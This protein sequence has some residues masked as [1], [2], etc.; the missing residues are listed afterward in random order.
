M[1]E[2]RRGFSAPAEVTGYFDGKSDRPGFSWLDVWGEE[3]AY[4]WTVAKA[5]DLELRTALR[6]AVS[7]GIAEGRTFENF[8]KD[9]EPELKR[10]GWWEPRLV[11]DPAGIDPD[12]IVDFSSPRRLQ[13]IYWS[14]MRAA[15]A[16]GQWQRIERA[17]RGLPFL[18]Y[19]RSSSAD[20]RPEHLAWVGVIL[21]VDHPW[22]RAHFPPNGW[23]CL[24]SV[25][26][27]SG[28]EAERLLAR[29]PKEGEIRYVSEP[30]D[31]GPP[32]DF[33]NRRTGEITVVPAGID[34][35]WHTS[36]GRARARTLIDNL[37]AR[38]DEADPADA[39]PVVEEAWKDPFAAIVPKLEE[40][41]WL[42]AGVSPKLETDLKAASPI[43][44]V[45]S[46]TI[47]DRMAKHGMTLDDF[48]Q[49]PQILSEA[50]VL[51]DLSP[52][53]EENVRTVFARFDKTWWRAIVVRSSTGLMRIRSLHQRD[54]QRV[55]DAILD[56]GLGEAM[57]LEAGFK[58]EEIARLIERWKGRRG[59]REEPPGS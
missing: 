50:P 6:T 58:P 53:R 12:A 18:L 57:L 40:K 55:A 42:P 3:H 26:Q 14:N 24:C 32:R 28:R 34:P 20:P 27:I 11:A 47:Q 30:P 39:R 44:A 17:K 59:G 56:E 21:P 10:I 23:G 13:T 29:E 7:R 5:T 36:P 19:V 54:A 22:W 49:L 35:G 8:V 15:R 52:K 41:V 31:V 38:L 9:L 2:V 48:A 1:S 51:P 37:A 25:R 46:A 43:V 16:A 33:R 4:S 45:D